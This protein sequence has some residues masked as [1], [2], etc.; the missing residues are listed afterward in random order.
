MSSGKLKLH[1]LESFI[2]KIVV[3]NQNYS[4]ASRKHFM[5]H[6]CG[7][8]FFRFGFF[9]FLRLVQV[10]SPSKKKEAVICIVYKKC[11]GSC[12]EFKKPVC[13]LESHDIE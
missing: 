2:F 5:L 9:F 11:L 3:L 13:S 4:K 1:N 7:Q 10:L 12:L 6:Q 8:G